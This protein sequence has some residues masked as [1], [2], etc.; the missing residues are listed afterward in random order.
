MTEMSLQTHGDALA[1]VTDLFEEKVSALSLPL[2]R[3]LA[4]ALRG[5]TASAEDLARAVITIA[6]DGPPARTLDGGGLG[7][8]VA[9]EVGAAALDEITSEVADEDWAG[10]DL[11]GAGE[12]ARRI[13]V[14]RTSLDNWRRVH[15][16][17]AFRKG[18]RNFVY[19]ARQFHH[20][21]P[22]EGIDR[23]W[24]RFDDDEIAWEWLI[25]ANRQTGGAAPIDWLRK[26]KVEDVARAAEGAFEFQ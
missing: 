17:I 13:G 1:T 2:L 24:T 16:V 26:G 12:T 18:I 9:R 5:P 14:A 15:K 23:V 6:G 10:S 19:P 4:R 11:F 7:E 8:I 25:T 3:K 20:Q 21:R 22:L